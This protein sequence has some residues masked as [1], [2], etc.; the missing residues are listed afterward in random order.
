MAATLSEAQQQRQ[1]VDGAG[2]LL[3]LLGARCSRV[4]LGQAELLSHCRRDKL[5]LIS[6]KA[7]LMKDDAKSFISDSVHVNT[8]N[9][10]G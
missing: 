4:I 10:F 3:G 2:G 1:D 9:L 7:P 8:F 5:K 6:D